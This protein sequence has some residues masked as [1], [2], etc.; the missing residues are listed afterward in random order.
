MAPLINSFVLPVLCMQGHH[1]PPPQ[2]CCRASSLCADKKEAAADVT[3]QVTGA[4]AHRNPNTFY[5]KNEVYLDVVE[6]VNV[7]I[8]KDGA[9]LLNSVGI[10]S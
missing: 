6:T 1:P 3:L 7:L 4:V 10:C 5:K 2:S 8:S 9:M